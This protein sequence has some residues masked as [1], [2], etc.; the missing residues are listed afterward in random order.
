MVE[1]SNASPYQSRTIHSQAFALQRHRGSDGWRPFWSGGGIRI[2][3]HNPAPLCCLD[4]RLRDANRTR[5]SH[6]CRGMAPTAALH[7]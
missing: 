4:D 7:R 2:L 1:F 5:A 3:R 6:T